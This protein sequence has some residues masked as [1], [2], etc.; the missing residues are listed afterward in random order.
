MDVFPPSASE[1][2]GLVPIPTKIY[3]IL[4]VTQES[5]TKRHSALVG[6][7]AVIHKALANHEM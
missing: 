7:L 6:I 4:T 5:C 2:E 1:S 3:P